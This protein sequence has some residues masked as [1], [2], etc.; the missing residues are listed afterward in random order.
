MSTQ[1]LWNKKV[2]ITRFLRY[3]IRIFYKSFVLYIVYIVRLLRSIYVGSCVSNVY[4]TTFCV[5]QIYKKQLNKASCK[6]KCKILDC[7]KKYSWQIFHILVNSHLTM[8]ESIERNLPV[9]NM[10][11]TPPQCL[12]IKPTPPQFLIWNL[13]LLSF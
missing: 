6:N 11:P 7:S 12:I 8:K 9:L 2:I 5:Q 4:F 1:K 10:K 3:D 13:P